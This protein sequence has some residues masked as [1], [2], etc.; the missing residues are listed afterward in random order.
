MWEAWTRDLSEV[1]RDKLTFQTRVNKFAGNG[2][3]VIMLILL[4]LDYHRESTDLHIGYIRSESHLD[5]A[6]FLHLDVIWTH[7]I[8]PIILVK[9]AHFI[10]IRCAKHGHASHCRFPTSWQTPKWCP[11]T[12]RPTLTEVEA[13]R[14]SILIFSL[15]INTNYP[16]D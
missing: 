10:K 1:I 2:D 12:T 13:E 9:I 16:D 3:K 15:I 7:L 11:N 4:R 8:K 5:L 14:V 6:L